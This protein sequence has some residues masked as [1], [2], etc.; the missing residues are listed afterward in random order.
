MAAEAPN[1]RFS[2]NT[3]KVGRKGVLKAEESFLLMLLS[4]LSGRKI[5]PRSSSVD[6]TCLRNE[7]HII[8]MTKRN[9]VTRVD[10]NFYSFFCELGAP[11]PE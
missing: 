8:P 3:F 11:L 10:L 2:Y 6:F 1:L 4:A 5:F 7:S 9:G